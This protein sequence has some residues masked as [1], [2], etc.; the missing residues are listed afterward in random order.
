MS[1][2]SQ[3]ILIIPVIATALFCLSK[4]AEMKFIDKDVKPVKV[5][6]RDA[7]I[8]FISSLTATFILFHFSNN[9]QDFLNVITDSKA[10][11]SSILGGGGGG[12]VSS[13]AEIFTDNPTF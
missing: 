8:V 1:A 10:T 13:A 6:F 4:F 12:G 7:L 2:I 5:I 9:I 11:A 3:N